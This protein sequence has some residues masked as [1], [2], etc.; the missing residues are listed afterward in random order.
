[1]LARLLEM[2]GEEIQKERGLG[3]CALEKWG[4]GNKEKIIPPPPP[5]SCF[6]IAHC[7]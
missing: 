5:Y 1:M 6:F 2:S 3:I 4:G 7:R